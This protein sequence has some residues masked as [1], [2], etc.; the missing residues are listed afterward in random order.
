MSRPQQ[1]ALIVAASLALPAIVLLLLT[2]LGIH[3]DP[4]LVIGGLVFVWAF[5]SGAGSARA[6]SGPRRGGPTNADDERQALAEL[7]KK[8]ADE[9]IEEHRAGKISTERRN[10][11]LRHILSPPSDPKGPGTRRPS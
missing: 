1:L 5:G 4:L 3:V 9:L 11:Q 2:V 7:Q 10:E 6:S 8:Y